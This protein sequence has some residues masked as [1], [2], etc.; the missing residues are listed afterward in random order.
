MG[1]LLHEEAVLCTDSATNYKSF[2]Q[3]NNINHEVINVRT[4]GYV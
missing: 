4:D 2:A 3:R 1:D